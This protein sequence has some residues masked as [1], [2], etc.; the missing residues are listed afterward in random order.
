[1]ENNEPEKSLTLS[2]LADDLTRHLDRTRLW[3]DGRVILI[4]A[5]ISNI[6]DLEIHVYSDHYPAHF[7]V[8]SKQRGI[9]ARFSLDSCELLNIK[10]GKKK[11]KSD[12]VKKI[13]AYFEW[14]P[15][16]LDFL[17]KEYLR[18]NKN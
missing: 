11:I 10:D 13:R 18:L 14:Y 1:M 12:D 16:K 6:G 15:N 9:N 3:E 17:R 7:H 5:F 4:K 2:T 8:I